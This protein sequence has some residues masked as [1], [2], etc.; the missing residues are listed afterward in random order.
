MALAIDMSGKAP[1]LTIGGEVL[2]KWMAE[3]FKKQPKST[4]NTTCEMR[5]HGNDV[6]VVTIPVLRSTTCWEV[7]TVIA[8]RLGIEACSLAFVSKQ[9]CTFRKCYDTEEI[10]R[11]IVIK[12]ISSFLRQKQTWEHPLVIIGTGHMGLREAMWFLRNQEYNFVVYDRKSTV[13]GTSWWDQA[14]TTS[15][16]QTEL[17]T[18]HLQYDEYHPVPKNMSTWPTRDELL[19]HFKDVS[20]EYGLIP[21]CKFN[22]NVKQIAIEK[23][24]PQAKAHGQWYPD[25]TY[26]LTLETVNSDESEYEASA[27]TIEIFPGNLSVARIE[28]YKGEELFGGMIEYGMHNNIDY[29]QVTGADVVLVGHGAFAVENVRTCAEFAV[30]KMFLVCRRKNLACPRVCSW[31]INQSYNMIS[32]VLYMRSTEPMYDLIGFDP[33][34]YHSVHSNE[35]RTHLTITQKARFGIGDVYFLSIAMGLLEVIEDKIK[36]LTKHCVHLDSGRKLDVTG[37]LKLLG[38]V[39]HWDNDR[40][41]GIKEMHGF[42][43]NGDFR[44]AVLAEPIGVN[45]NNFGGTSFSPGARTWAEQLA[46]FLWFPKDYAPLYEGGLLPKHKADPDTDRPAYVIDARHGTTTGM[47]LEGSVLAFQE[48]GPTRGGLKRAKQLECHPMEKF[49]DECAA[50]WDAYAKKWKENGAPGPIPAYP[51]TYAIVNEFLAAELKELQR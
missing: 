41:M 19:V 5:C 12:G 8:T 15:K 37:I 9:G 16:L 4:G 26:K 21:Y 48:S 32:G 20:E 1:T 2:P 30:R 51:Y 45:A 46:H 29:S 36:R 10:P 6:E 31:L 27:S 44:R 47:L 42:W 33:W 34:A 39:G 40:L 18:Y 7:K 23:G 22:T 50:E 11:K 14:N 13:G 38:F 28:T 35:K 3:D 24:N 17:G 25:Q 49:I 43:V